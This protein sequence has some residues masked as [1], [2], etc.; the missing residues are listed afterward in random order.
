MIQEICL[1]N[2]LFMT[3]AEL[4]FCRGLNVITG[5]TGAGKSVLLEAVRLLLGKKA[6]SRIIMPQK[7]SAR[8]QAQFCISEQP[9]LQNFL[10]SSGFLNEDAPEILTISRTFRQDAPGRIMVNGMLTTVG[11]L[12]QLGPHLMEIH[13]QNEHQTLLQPDT[14]RKYLDRTGNET[15]LTNLNEL[16]KV[17]KERQKLQQEFLELEQRQQHSSQRVQ[18]LQDLLQELEKLGLNDENEEEELKEELKKLSHSE[19]ILSMLQ[20]AS[21]ALKGEDEISGATSL[22]YKAS[23]SLRQISDFGPELE[24][25]S[26]RANN[27]Y[28]ELQDLETELSSFAETTDLDPDKL[29]DIQ[30]RLSEISRL[31]RKHNSSFKDLFVL[32]NRASNELSDLFEPDNK[33]QKLRRQLD[34][35]NSKFNRLLEE[36]SNSRKKLAARLEKAV[37]KEM[38]NLGFNAANFKVKLQ[39]ITATQ[40]GAEQIEFMVSLNPGMPGGPLRK[41]A[42][43]GELSRVALAI[44]KVL[45]KNDD[46]PTL[47]F[48][49]ID[50]GIGGKTAEAVAASLSSLAGEKQVLLV[51]H[52]HQIAKEGKYHFSVIKKIENNS[53][54]VEI[55]LLQEDKR[56]SE[57]ARMLGHTDSEG[58]AFAR[59]LLQKSA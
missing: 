33:R 36:I 3:K 35:I 25:F 20:A 34:E 22:C 13:G 31:C 54:I 19:Q 17:F 12:K 27:L 14:Q 23:D 38:H 7:R 55:E 28:H 40:N 53:T 11:F 29:Y 32:R 48:D 6:R 15:H 37:S 57:I 1:E 9:E 41:I 46:L 50:A 43:G 4:S 45:A 2:F 44:K 49:E 58:I 18:E 39:E 30:A 42:S 10:E 56:I 16:K 59:N 21:I 5:E 24:T 47:L 8:V 26:G 52:L 51:T